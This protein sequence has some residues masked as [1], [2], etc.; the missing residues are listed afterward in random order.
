MGVKEKKQNKRDAT[1]NDYIR[2]ES[3]GGMSLGNWKT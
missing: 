1:C 3:K 2:N